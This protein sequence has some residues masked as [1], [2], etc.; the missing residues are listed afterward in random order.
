MK[1]NNGRGWKFK[2]AIVMLIIASIF[3]LSRIIVLG[4][5]E[6]VVSYLW[7]QIGFIPVNIL[8][9][10]LLID[11]IMSKKE[12]EAI[13]EKIDML[14]GTFFTKIGNDLI[15]EVSKVNKNKAKTEDLKSIKNWTDKDY[16]NKLKKLRASPIDFE[17]DITKE[18]R[19][20]FLTNIHVMIEK[21]R[22]FIINLINNPH[23]FEKDE[24]SALVLALLHLDEELSRRED[25]SNIDDVDFN[26]L[27]GDIKRVYTHLIYEWIYYLRYLNQFYPYMIS[28][29]IR[30][31]PFDSDSDV[32]VTE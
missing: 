7:K 15:S 21:N 2:F 22:D 13:L 18:E 14:M 16:E 12:R 26:H 27:T 31:N 23:L 1:E 9:V 19:E 30:T 24:F 32:H 8:I 11:G 17:T 25:L 10:A 29:A 3:F 28:L 4:D 20:E 5:P 6:E